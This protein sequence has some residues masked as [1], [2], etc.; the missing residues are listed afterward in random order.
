MEGETLQ[1][2]LL[3]GKKLNEGIHNVLSPSR[4]M[5]EADFSKPA[6]TQNPA[7]RLLETQ[8]GGAKT[9]GSTAGRA[10]LRDGL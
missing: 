10:A 5:K 7:K 9:R 4:K 1:K 8:R 2:N 6:F 3:P